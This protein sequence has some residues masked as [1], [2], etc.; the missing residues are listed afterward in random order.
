M[1][2]YRYTIAALLVF[3]VLLAWVLTQERGRVPEKGEVF[4]LQISEIDRLEVEQDDK[5]IALEKRGEDWYLV[6]PVQG[7]A[8]KDTV[9]PMV[10]A[11]A[12]L[13]TDV[14]EDAD[15]TAPEYGLQA[16]V[17]MVVFTGLRNKSTTIKLGAET[18]V[19]GKLFATISGRAHLHLVPTMFKSQLDKEFEDLREK[20]LAPGL[21]ADDVQKVT[22]TRGEQ[23]IVAQKTKN[24]D[25]DLW[26]LREPLDTKADRWAVQSVVDAIKNAEARDFAQLPEDMN[27]FGLDEPQAL[28]TLKLKDSKT[29]AV[30]LG[31]EVT[32]E[33][34]K[35]FSE[36]TETKDL[37]YVQTEGRPEILLVESDLVAKVS[38]KVLELRD[39]HILELARAEV[40]GIKVQRKRGLS[41]EAHKV[42]DEWTLRVPAGVE[43][44]QTKIDDILFDLEDME[45]TKFIEQPADDLGEYGLEVPHTVIS[46]TL[47][48]QTRPL[49][50]SFGDRVKGSSDYYCLTS[51]SYQAYQLSDMVL[52]GLPED[53]EQLKDG[54]S[55]TDQP[56][57]D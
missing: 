46:L 35:T 32:K 50:I 22:I 54:A 34:K 12:E 45:A 41:F 20:S 26:R 2:R 5:K 17:M 49:K 31:R 28:V 55:T 13:K 9:E 37:V 52:S 24:D 11:V 51:Q 15:L 57:Y 27:E 42:G 19:G 4:R 16:P 40:I 21:K 29:I 8:D 48:G 38:K 1:Q 18:P 14:R 33:V 10:K 36:E 3:A 23:T 56:D 6:E 44:D 7:L 43:P 30:S 25:K 47:H 53:V 39:K